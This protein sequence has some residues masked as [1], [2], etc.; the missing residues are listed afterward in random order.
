MLPYRAAR[1]PQVVGVLGRDDDPHH[2]GGRRR[3]GD[4]E[5]PAAAVP[6][7]AVVQDLLGLVTHEVHGCAVVAVE[8]DGAGHLDAAARPVLE[9]AGREVRNGHGDAAF[10]PGAYGEEGEG[11]VLDHPPLARDDDRVAD[12]YHVA[13]G[14]LEARE[15]VSEGGLG[16]D[17]GHDSDDSGGGQHG[18]AERA[19]AREGDEHRGDGDDG[20]ED[21]HHPH[22]QGH[23]GADAAQSGRVAGG[24]GVAGVPRLDDGGGHGYEQPGPR[25]DQGEGERPAQGG[26]VVV[27]RWPRDLPIGAPEQCGEQHDQQGAPAPAQ[28][29][30]QGRL[31]V[32]RVGPAQQQVDDPTGREGEQERAAQDG[33]HTKSAVHIPSS[34]IGDMDVHAPARWEGADTGGLVSLPF[35]RGTA[36]SCW[37]SD[38]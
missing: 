22:D 15:E 20:H 25:A 5:V 9:G 26:G 30:P 38:S 35:L 21:C 1:R 28:Q 7:L 11:D 23:L 3:L 29:V 37:S 19:E 17:A 24:G 36:K 14:D 33:Q 6:L 32:T 10:V 18:G 27:Q 34:D 31:G 4:D 2:D 13:E 8:E 12:A 16:G